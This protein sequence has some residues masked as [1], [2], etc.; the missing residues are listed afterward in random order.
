MQ[1][2]CISTFFIC[3]LAFAAPPI[4]ANDMAN[5]TLLAATSALL[6]LAAAE[7]NYRTPSLVRHAWPVRCSGASGMTIIGC[8]E[9]ANQF[10]CMPW[11]LYTSDRYNLFSRLSRRLQS[12]APGNFFDILA[13]QLN[14]ALK[15]FAIDHGYK[16]AVSGNEVSSRSKAIASTPKRCRHVFTKQQPFQCPIKILLHIFLVLE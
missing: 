4:L 2:G 13:S 3:R 15:Y 7:T 11:A 6:V 8:V 10:A 12:D 16:T 14:A 9:H 1:R 5:S